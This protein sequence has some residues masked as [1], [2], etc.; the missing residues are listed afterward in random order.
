MSRLKWVNTKLNQIEARD[1]ISMYSTI[2]CTLS[3]I[4]LTQPKHEI[5]H[6]DTDLVGDRSKYTRV[7]KKC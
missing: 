3:A 5:F 7:Q 2:G 4:I 1:E 6:N